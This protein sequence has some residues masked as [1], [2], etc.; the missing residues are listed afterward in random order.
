MPFDGK[1]VSLVMLPAR[2]GAISLIFS[3]LDGGADNK[4][5]T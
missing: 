1:S 2:R 3:F 5:A 4:E